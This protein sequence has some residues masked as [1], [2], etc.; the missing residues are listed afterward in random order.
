MFNNIRVSTLAATLG[1]ALL[2]ATAV[3]QLAA[4]E[5]DKKTF[6]TFNAPVEI[7]GRVLLP[8]TYVFKTI[9]N[10]GY[11]V[12][13]YNAD[14]NRVYGTFHATPVESATIPDKARVEL[15]ESTGSAPEAIRAWFYPG[16]SHGWEFP[17]TRMQKQA[18]A[19]RAD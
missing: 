10:D 1:V 9:G 4:S 7:S 16:V 6:V 8:G 15:S 19:E 11:V 13:V 12:T 3:P 14:E 17:A 5:F 2:A 18:A